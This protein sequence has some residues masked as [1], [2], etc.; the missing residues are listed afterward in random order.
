LGVLIDAEGKITFYESGYEISEL[1]AA[2]AKLGPPFSS[3]APAAKAT[4]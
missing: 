1:R 4:Q 2:I 3:L